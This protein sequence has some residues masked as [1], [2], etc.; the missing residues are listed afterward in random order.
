MAKY[1][2]MCDVKLGILFNKVTLKDGHAC[3]NCIS[4]LGFTTEQIETSGGFALKIADVST[5]DIRLAI[6]GDKEKLEAIWNIVVPTSK[7]DKNIS[8]GLN[9]V[10]EGDYKGYSVSPSLGSIVFSKFLKDSIYVNSDNVINYKIIPNDNRE[11][12]SVSRA[13]VM[14]N[15][16]QTAP[17]LTALTTLAGDGLPGKIYVVRLDFNNGRKSLIR[18]NE[19]IFNNLSTVLKISEYEGWDND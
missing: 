12:E 4:S 1:C 5:E 2:A 11:L 17:T 16:L 8:T 7:S 3:R 19:R 10:I 15:M 6:N 14:A 13:N 18:I 9:I